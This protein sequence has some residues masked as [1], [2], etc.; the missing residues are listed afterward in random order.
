MSLFEAIEAYIASLE[1]SNNP[2]SQIAFIF[3]FVI[4]YLYVIVVGFLLASIMKTFIRN[5]VFSQ[6]C[7]D[8]NVEFESKLRVLGLWWIMVSNILLLI[9]TLG[10]AKPFTL[11]R[12]ARYMAKQTKVISSTNL[13]QFVGEKRHEVGAFGDELGDAFDMDMDVG[14]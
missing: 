4:G 9:I 3:T 1:D 11:V 8:K 10:L 14:F 6:A 13:A 7:L 5:Y 2:Q 12:M